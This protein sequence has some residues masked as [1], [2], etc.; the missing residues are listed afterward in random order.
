MLIVITMLNIGID[1]SELLTPTCSVRHD[2]LNKPLCRLFTHYFGANLAFCLFG[3]VNED[4]LWLG[5]AKADMVHYIH[6]QL[7]GCAA[8]T[9]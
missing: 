9:V 8:K 1:F 3:L 5:K 7:C 6:E 4:R 2:G